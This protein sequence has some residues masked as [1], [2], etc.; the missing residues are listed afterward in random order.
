MKQIN[1]LQVGATDEEGA[2]FNGQ[3]LHKE[4]RERG[5]RSHHMV[6]SK[7]GDDP[8]TSEIKTTKSIK[9]QQK[10]QRL[11]YKFSLQSLLYPFAFEFPLRKQFKEADLV[12]YH[13]LH[14]GY[15]SLGALPLLTRMKPSVWT[16]HDPWAMT[17][18]CVHPFGCDRWKIGCGN[19]PDL[20]IM[21]PLQHDNTAFLWKAKKFLYHASRIDIVLASKWMMKMAEESPLMSNFRLHHI[22][23]GIDTQLFAPGDTADCKAKLGIPKD[24]LVIGLRA[25]SNDFKG[26]SYIQEMFEHLDFELPITILAFNQ[27]GH[28]DKYLGRHHIVEVGWIKESSAYAQTLQACDLFLMPST[29]ESFGMMAIESMACGKPSIVFDGTAL[30]EVTFA[31]RGAISIP[32]NANELLKATKHLLT[33]QR[34]RKQLGDEARNLSVQN[35]DF[36]LHV[37]RMQN[38]YENALARAGTAAPS[39]AEP[40]RPA[41]SSHK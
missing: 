21:F 34:A 37:D 39:P 7:T 27:K 4:L 17:G 32:K 31:P 19:C 22:P 36:K 10:I 40:T 23:F 14:T 2:R 29:A 6:W 1:I 38:L 11:E 8:D 12:H 9:R 20:K 33:D 25:N 26:L 41:Q 15:F 28:F 30:P 18:H 3:D 24:N 35:Y 16:L 5:F 13:L